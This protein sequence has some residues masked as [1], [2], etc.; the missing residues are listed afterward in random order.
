MMGRVFF[1][2]GKVDMRAPLSLPS[3]YTKLAY[4]QSS[5]TQ[6]VDSGFKPNNNSRVIL[7]FEPTAAYSSI[8]GIFGTRD[9]NSGTAA[10]MFVFWNNGANTFRTDYFGT[11]QTM[12][13]ST[14]LARQTVDKDK[15]VTT[16]GSVSAS[17]AASTGQCANNLYLFCTN[18]AG[19]VDYFAKLKLYSCKIYDN[20]TLVRDFVPCISDS[21]AV[22]LYD[23]VNRQFYGN[24]GTGTFTGSE[25]E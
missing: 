13:V 15:N 1:G 9:E 16:I 3:G 4:I 18:A 11:Q 8:V 20:G 21:G 5:G 12:T 17:N 24:A 25:V 10:N 7:D 23:L 6:Y 19:T 14:L 2:G 22:G